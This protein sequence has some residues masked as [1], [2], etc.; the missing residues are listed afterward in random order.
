MT[1]TLFDALAAGLVDPEEAKA[2]LG[3]AARHAGGRPRGR[4][5]R[6]VV[7]AA[8]SGPASASVTRPRLSRMP[9]TRPLWRCPSGAVA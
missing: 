2:I 7:G 9:W 3:Q 1:N 4:G 8:R 6:A 5:T